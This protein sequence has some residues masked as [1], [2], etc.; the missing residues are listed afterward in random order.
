MKAKNK[1]TGEIVDVI[2]H[3]CLH[4]RQKTDSVTYMKDSV[5]TID[6]GANFYLDFEPVEAPDWEK[7]RYETAKAVLQG[8]MA[9]AKIVGL[10]D[11]LNMERR[12]DKRLARSAVQIA[13][14]L[15]EELKNGKK[16]EGK[17]NS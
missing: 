10:D 15:L 12:Y 6:D 1:D 11:I 5:L 9:N 13:D 8:M 2:D 7:R 16:D 17:T 3:N 14:T 4:H